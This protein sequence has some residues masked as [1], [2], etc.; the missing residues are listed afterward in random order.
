M[1]DSIGISGFQS[2]ENT[3]LNFCSGVNAIIG[4]SDCG[5]SAIL[6]A[7]RFVLENKPNGDGFINHSSKEAI[8]IVSIDN[9]KS[10][11]RAKG[12][13]GNEYILHDPNGNGSETFTAFGKGVP[14]PITQATRFHDANFQH[15]LDAPFLLSMTP[16][17]AGQYLN[18]IMNLDMIDAAIK[19]AQAQARENKSA[20][21]SLSSS[22]AL[23]E[24][25]E[26]TFSWIDEAESA[27]AKLASLE[28]KRDEIDADLF[29][30][31]RC[32]EFIE[33]VEISPV[34]D[35]AT[36]L[37][38]LRN[39]EERLDGIDQANGIIAVAID[40]AEECLQ[41]VASSAIDIQNLKA[42]LAEIKICS[43]CGRPL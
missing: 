30:V 21:T 16:G 35:V 6:R 43:E 24:S 36:K 12:I 14:E 38:E 27:V 33:G 22:I 37:E 31:K 19:A 9:V 13:R 40:R 42:K 26:K 25:E 28:S 32:I 2:H 34:P 10:I 39:A 18:E 17:E 15:Q 3:G 41:L 5:K 1:I 7:L 29:A 11:V 23:L 4:K 20:I 8:V